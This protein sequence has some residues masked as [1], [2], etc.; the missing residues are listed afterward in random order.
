MAPLTPAPLL[1]A[2]AEH[3]RMGTP[4]AAELARSIDAVDEGAR[5]SLSDDPEAVYGIWKFLR[6]V[7]TRFPLFQKHTRD[8]RKKLTLTPLSPRPPP[9]E[10]DRKRS[11][12]T[13]S[14]E[15]VHRLA[16]LLPTEYKKCAIRPDTTAP[17]LSRFRL[18]F[19][20]FKRRA[21]SD[22]APH[23]RIARLVRIAG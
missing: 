22:H 10:L 18:T 5:T 14:P 19:F 12:T 13:G 1:A 9:Q 11:T 8:T 20:P 3:P 23:L 2:L 21:F 7:G 17:A 16:K 15:L 6:T 4:H